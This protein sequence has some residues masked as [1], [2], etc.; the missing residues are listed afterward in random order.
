LKKWKRLEKILGLLIK[1]RLFVSNR[2]HLILPYHRVLEAAI[3]THLGEKK[4][5]R[6]H[7]IGPAYEDKWAAAVCGVRLLERS[8]S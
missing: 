6:H 8:A 4:L 3:E 1:G 2:C 7:G 5:E